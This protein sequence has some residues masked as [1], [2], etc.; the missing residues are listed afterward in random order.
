M[1]TTPL[2]VI[3]VKNPLITLQNK[4]DK[5]R[6][7]SDHGPTQKT[8]KILVGVANETG[9]ANEFRCVQ[10]KL[11]DEYGCTT[12]HTTRLF[13]RAQE[14][15][16]LE[17]GIPRVQRNGKG[18]WETIR[19]LKLTGM[20][21]NIALNSSMILGQD[22]HA[23]PFKA[24][25]IPLDPRPIIPDPE[26]ID[27]GFASYDEPC[28]E[29]MKEILNSLNMPGGL[30]GFTPFSKPDASQHGKEKARKRGPRS[31]RSTRP[32]KKSADT[33]WKIVNDYFKDLHYGSYFDGKAYNDCMDQVV[34][35]CGSFT[36]TRAMLDRMKAKGNNHILHERRAA[37]SRVCQD[38]G[39]Y[40]RVRLPSKLGAPLVI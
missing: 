34:G 35:M 26:S 7:Y 30:R 6:H 13:A 40:P 32:G 4:A 14:E 11:A 37:F 22:I 21:I 8:L 15:G 1:Y 17:L 19:H 38:N 33:S 2:S 23:A 31:P 27:L 12:R 9:I 25:P 3:Q 24:S 18:G 28:P 29:E 5:A 36:E 16:L 10:G 20:A 39:I